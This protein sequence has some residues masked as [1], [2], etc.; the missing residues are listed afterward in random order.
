MVTVFTPT[1][2]RVH[3]L[4]R[5]YHSLTKQSCMDFEWL[6]IDD[7]STDGTQHY[8]ENI[9]SENKIKIRYQRQENSG[10][11]VAHNTAVFLAEGEWFYC[12]DSDDWLTENSISE[13]SAALKNTCASDCALIGYK[14]LAD[15]S[16]L[17]KPFTHQMSHKGF[18]DMV[19]MGDGG[20]YSIVLKTELLREQLFPVVPGEKFSK[21]AI[22]Y[23]KL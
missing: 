19:Q 12:V 6:V 1:Y 11:H 3:L 21:E 17:C 23:D 5:L 13:I 18:Y 14:M 9:Q 8:I 16:M 22:L 20:E 4:D 15:G 7:G 2:N 10:K